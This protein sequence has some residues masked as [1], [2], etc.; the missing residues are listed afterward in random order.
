M[1]EGA[2]VRTILNPAGNRSPMR[3]L[4][5]RLRIILAAALA[6]WMIADSARAD[7]PEI[8]DI[9]LP[10]G[11]FSAGLTEWTTTVSPPG[12]MPAGSVTVVDGA[13]RLGKGGAFLTGISQAFAAPEDLVALRLT[14]AELPQFG[15]TGSFIPEALDIHLTG[16]NGFSRVASFRPDASSAVNAAALPPGFNLGSGVTWDGQVV[17][18]AIEDV[19][20]GELLELSATLVGASADTQASVSIDDAVM[21]VLI[22]L[23]PDRLDGCG[24]FRDRFEI[25]HGVAGIARCAQGQ[26][27]D[28]GI[29]TCVGGN[30]QGTCPVETLP[31]QDGDHGRD[32]LE[33]AGQLNKL[34]KGPAGFDYTKL[35]IDGEALPPAAD[36]WACVRDNYSGLT[37]E[38]KVDDPSNPRHHGHTFTW[39]QPDAATNGGQTGQADGGLCTGS[40]CDLEGLVTAVNDSRLCGSTDWRVPTRQELM[41]LVNAG[42]ASPAISAVYFPLTDGLFWSLTPVAADPSAAWQVDFAAGE[43]AMA[44][45][46]AALKVRLVQET[47]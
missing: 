14:I 18:I 41:S 28:T 20:P 1:M 33:R 30:G 21:E 11:D 32:A 8:I 22:K 47:K 31:G 19:D 44:D 5:R 43:V 42:E 12:A 15:S 10:N 24:I 26:L 27:N 16:A 45:K 36:A 38:V 37:W 29:S 39:Y 25:S 6:C 17:R 13:A 40:P 2:A 46:S 3:D 34:G 7:D 35:D 23:V 9:P 4:D